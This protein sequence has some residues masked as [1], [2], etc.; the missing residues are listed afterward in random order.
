MLLYYIRHGDPIY[1]PDSLTALGKRQAE[2]VGRRLAVH[3]MDKIFAS[4]SNRAYQTALPLSELV[5]KD[6]Q[7]MAFL[8]EEQ[9]WKYFS[10]T[11]DG[12]SAWLYQHE[13]YR[14]LFASSQMLGLG[15]QWYTHPEFAQ[16]SLE[17]GVRYFDSH[18][19]E[20]LFSLGYEHDRQNHCYRALK[21]NHDRVA[22]FAHEGVG[23]AVLSS[24]LDIPYALFAA[25]YA[26]GHTGVTVIKFDSVGE[27]IV[28][29]LLQHSNDSHIYKEGLPTSYWNEFFV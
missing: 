4:T 18:T 12:R 27:K 2:A 17:E 14:R 22:I 19:D 9:A 1:N 20:L 3:G 5:K 15:Y 29:R 11:R 13:Y 25:H 16:F 28:P 8:H 23:S 10:A 26:I 21:E 24:I 7:Q 6:I